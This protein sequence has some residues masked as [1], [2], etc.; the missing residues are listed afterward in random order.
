MEKYGLSP[1]SL[2]RVL[3]Q[4]QEERDRRASR[5]I[6]DF[7]SG[8]EVQDIAVRNDFPASRFLDILRKV[9]CLRLS[10]AT[11]PAGVINAIAFRDADRERRRYPRIRCPVLKS[12]AR[13]V[14]CPA[15]EG[16]ILDISEKGVAVRGVPARVDD[17]KTFLISES[18]VELPDPMILT[19][20]CRW[21]DE[22]PAPNPRQTAGFEIVGIS[23]SDKRHLRSWIHAEARMTCSQSFVSA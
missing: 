5:I 12:H 11:D 14:S 22:V 10:S 18:D 13:D 8:M 17:K 2:C 1:A 6:Q 19:C 7:L 15:T 16:T 4:I 20:T 23:E 3:K 21:T 9:V